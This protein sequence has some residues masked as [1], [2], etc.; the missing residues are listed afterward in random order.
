MRESHH[1]ALS[2]DGALKFATQRNVPLCS[3]RKL[4]PEHA[5]EIVKNESTE[6]F[7]NLQSILIRR[8]LS[9]NRAVATLQHVQLMPWTSIGMCDVSR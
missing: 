3:F 6:I 8:H 4:I 2:G 7:V 9:E 5:L 1:C